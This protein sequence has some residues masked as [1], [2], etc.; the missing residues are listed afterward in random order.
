VNLE[1]VHKPKCREIVTSSIRN[2]FCTHAEEGDDI[3]EHLNELE[4]YWEQISLNLTGDEDLEI[5]DRG[6]KTI[7]AA[8]LPPSWDAFT[9]PYSGSGK[10]PIYND[11]RKIVYTKVMI[12]VIKEEYLFRE[13]RKRATA[14]KATPGN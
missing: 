12:E 9:E 8:S 10:G 4:R 3:I 2:L 6:F 7:I 1:A 14:H 13:I 11:P 5:S